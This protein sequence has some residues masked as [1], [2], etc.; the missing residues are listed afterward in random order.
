MQFFDFL[1]PDLA[2]T[3]KDP[4]KRSDQIFLLSGI[5]S[6][7]DIQFFP[8]VFAIPVLGVSAQPGEKLKSLRGGTGGGEAEIALGGIFFPPL[9]RK[10]LFLGLQ[11]CIK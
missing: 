6:R 8:I 1:R 4:P 2:G 11:K 7:R 3:Q 9:V 10:T 5:R